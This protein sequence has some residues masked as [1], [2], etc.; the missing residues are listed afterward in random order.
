MSSRLYK[1]KPIA[2]PVWPT[3]I[4][5]VGLVILSPFV[6][7]V[8]DEAFNIVPNSLIPLVAIFWF[9]SF[10]AANLLF[11]HWGTYLLL[12]CVTLICAV[13]ILFQKHVSFWKKSIALLTVILVGL[14]M[15][16]PYSPAVQLKHEARKMLIST[17]PALPFRG[18][19]VA[20]SMGEMH[21][22]A[23]EILGW[24]DA[25][26]F[27]ES[28]CSGTVL[29]WQYNIDDELL[30]TVK[31]APS[32]ERLW[33]NQDDHTKFVD[34][35]RM[36]VHPSELE[37]SIIELAL[38]GGAVLSSNQEWVAIVARHSVYGPEDVLIVRM[39]PDD[40]NPS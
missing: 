2:N 15:F 12:C 8:L 33:N 23:Y 1:N 13:W 32:K 19:K 14:F 36:S 34:L 27:Y 5:I 7:Q 38:R 16:L 3:R 30:T 21:P 29:T 22:C 35:F 10:A 9:W 40:L 11:W 17:A 20:Q 24:Q 37:K 31:Q 39:M 25:S 6:L 4:T 28:T 26:L 18:L